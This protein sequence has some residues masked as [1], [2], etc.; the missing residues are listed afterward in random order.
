M[1]K[2]SKLYCEPVQVI[3]GSD[4]LPA[5][6]NWRGHWY[7][8]SSISMIIKRQPYWFRYRYWLEP[9]LRCETWE[10]LSCDLV[11]D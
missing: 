4:S 7:H 6:F 5:Q 8:I 11:W 10:G 9:R 1:I 3:P 2:M